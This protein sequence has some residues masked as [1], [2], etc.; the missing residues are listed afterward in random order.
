MDINNRTQSFHK[1]HD[2][3]YIK[4]E[5]K[6]KIIKLPFDIHVN[7]ASN[8]LIT[9][10]PMEENLGGEINNFFMRVLPENKEGEILKILTAIGNKAKIEK[11]ILNSYLTNILNR[12]DEDKIILNRDFSE[13]ISVVLKE[14]F[15]KIKKKTKIKNFDDF[16]AKAQK[17]MDN[18]NK[19]D[20]LSYFRVENSS[21]TLGSGF[22]LFESDN[23]NQEKKRRN[24]DEKYEYKEIK[25]SKDIQ[26]PVE[27]LILIRKFNMTKT[28]KLTINSDYYSISDDISKSNE[29]SYEKKKNDLENIILILFNLEWLFPSL[30]GLELDFSNSNLLESQINLYKYT[31]DVF[32]KL[33]NKD[34]KITTYQKFTYNNKRISEP[35]Y[36]PN[37][38]Q[39][40]YIEESE[41]SNDKTSTS[42]MS[43]NHIFLG[44]DT[45]YSEVVFSEEKYNKTFNKFIEK[46]TNIM[47]MMIIYS[48]FI[49][50]MKSIIN[51]KFIMPIN[52][53]QEIFE[54]LKQKDIFMDEFHILSFFTKKDLI[55]LTIEFNSLDS[56]MFEK[57]LN[58]LNQN[59]FLGKL[60]MSFFPEEEFFKTELL[61]NLLQSSDEDFKLKRNKNNKLCFNSNINL[62]TKVNE[63]LDEIILRKLSENFEKNIQNFFYL[64]TMKTNINDLV[65]IFDI[66]TIMSKNDYYN[67]ILMKFIL[68]LFIMIDSSFNNNIIQLSLI[69]ENFIFDG[70]KNPFLIDFCDKINLFNKIN[71]K[72]T[73]LI[74]H[75]KFY[76]IPQIYRFISSNL[77]Y[78]SIGS[79]DFETFNILVNYLTS[80]EFG[81]KSKLTQLKISLNNSLVD[82]NEHNLYDIL[83]RLFTEYPKRLTELSLYSYLLI[84]FEQL[85]SLLRKTDYNS[86]SYIFLQLSIKSFVTRR[87][88]EEK[89]EYDTTTETKNI[90]LKTDNLIKLFTIKR[91]S[92]LTDKIIN[93]LM[94]LVKVNESIFHYQIYAN[95]E[96]F[97]SPKECKKVIIEF[98]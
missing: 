94:N 93:L 26:L 71:H 28:L 38:S 8:F 19:D 54:F 79:L 56:Q 74:F 33:V 5:R 44:P 61:F 98:K 59:S 2:I 29:H 70:R 62:D 85:I 24:N 11:N 53:G 20:I 9:L 69:A 51:A 1:K 6:N 90:N 91:N 64:L 17:Y 30:V 46:Y 92:E 76:R 55:D 57:I 43:N 81:T 63:S 3:K 7:E 89:F 84:P 41:S 22:N 49:G 73:V 32:S 23:N 10:T 13:E 14:I 31:L 97:L 86:L 42:N 27:M 16:K 68:D 35:L 25:L 37:F 48:Y 77:I 80:S 75:L 4:I 67:N 82:F 50:K 65:L 88:I 52:I 78:L 66:P 60:N 96:K 36:K 45:D 72:L 58:F 12:P 34:T 15:K 21:K 39:F 83:I 18:L 40:S 87:T 95:I 47:E